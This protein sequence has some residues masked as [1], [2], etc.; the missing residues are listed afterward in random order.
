MAFCRLVFPFLVISVVSS[1]ANVHVPV[2]LWGDL[3]TKSI[4]S[5]P[6]TNVPR[7]TFEETLKSELK[8]D[9]FTVI[10]IDKTLSV[11]DFSLKN[12]EGDTSFPYLHANIGKALYLP[13]VEGALDVLNHIADPEKVDHVKLTENGLSAEFEPKSGK[14]LFINLND[15]IEG[16]S[17]AD[18]LRR[19][20]DFMEDMFTKLTKKYENVV[21]VY[22]AEYPSWIISSSHSRVRRQAESGQIDEA[23]DGL[24]LYVKEITLTIGTE[25]TSLNNIA[26]YSTEFNDTLM[27][28]TMNFGENSLTL[29]F[30]QK[31]GYWFFNSVTLKQT[32]PKTI[33]E[34]L[35]PN[36]DVHAIMG[37]SYRCGQSVSFNSVND[38]QT[39]NLL[40]QDLKVQPFFK[41]TGNTTLEF[42]ESINCVGFFTVPIWSG[43]F[44]VFILLA[45]TF[46]GIM[47]MMDIR[48]M[49]RFDDPKGKTITINT[50][51]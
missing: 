25:K 32:S 1:Y 46:Y 42:G 45:I 28:T 50:A 16:E 27:S 47:M 29:N 4:K 30:L 19:H 48:T 38:T 34:E 24:K 26:S 43:L 22:T 8:D 35:V 13:S 11:E 41:E 15:A 23:M 33:T 9:P 39:Y 20:N 31:A 5:N 6:L 3:K 40:F 44:V 12:S 18:M 21:A 37:F 17:R 51:E 7:D 36:S 10:F 49:D 2:F 14:F